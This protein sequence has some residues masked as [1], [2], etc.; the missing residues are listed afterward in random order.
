MRRSDGSAPGGPLVKLLALAGMRCSF[1]RRQVGADQVLVDL[2]QFDMV[3]IPV[4]FALIDFH[5]G[6]LDASS[7]TGLISLNCPEVS[8]KLVDDY[9]P[10]KV[11][12]TK[13]CCMVLAIDDPRH[14]GLQCFW[15][16]LSTKRLPRIDDL[17]GRIHLDHELRKIGDHDLTYHRFNG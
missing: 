15:G 14:G 9:C 7:V 13:V 6:F 1:G 5:F 2:S 3:R 11:N 4:A 10:I 17:A 16:S 12:D 8:H